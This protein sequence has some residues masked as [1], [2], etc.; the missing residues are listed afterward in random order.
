VVDRYFAI[1]NGN[2]Q[3]SAT[4]IR[5]LPLPPREAIEQVGRLCRA[6]GLEPALDEPGFQRRVLDL[7][8]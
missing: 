6:E 7:L 3:V 5:Q 2:T 8:P 4:E 1:S